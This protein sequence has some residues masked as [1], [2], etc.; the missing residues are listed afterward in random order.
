[1]GPQSRI[2]VVF[3]ALLKFSTSS[4][5][6]RDNENEILSQTRLSIDRTTHTSH[7]HTYRYNGERDSKKAHSLGAGSAKL[8]T[9]SRGILSWKIIRS[10]SS[11]KSPHS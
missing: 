8:L 1:M 7:T 4:S 10:F 2:F 11:T 9:T 5:V 6:R 3:G